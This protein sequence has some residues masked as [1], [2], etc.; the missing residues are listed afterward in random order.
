MNGESELGPG[1]V[2]GIHRRVALHPLCFFSF[3]KIYYIHIEMSSSLL[4][5]CLGTPPLTPNSRHGVSFQLQGPLPLEAWTQGS[6]ALGSDEDLLEILALF[7]LSSSL[8]F[9]PPPPGDLAGVAS[10]L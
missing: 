2:W 7:F 3:S 8:P 5:P 9:T 4:P 10:D 6:R 1:E